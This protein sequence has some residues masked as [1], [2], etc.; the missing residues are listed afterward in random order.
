VPF[1]ALVAYLFG[2]TASLSPAIATAGISSLALAVIFAGMP[3]PP[4][5]ALVNSGW[6][7]LGAVIQ[8]VIWLIV[9]RRERRIFV[10]RAVSA[11]IAAIRALVA[12]SA[13]QSRSVIRAL[14]SLESARETLDC[15]G[16]PADEERALRQSLSAAVRATRA[17]CCWLLLKVPGEEDRL[18][19]ALTLSDAA[20]QLDDRPWPSG[21]PS[22]HVPISAHGGAERGLVDAL[23]ELQQS[24]NA[25][26]TYQAPAEVDL[27]PVT[28][29]RAPQ[30]R[31]TLS[32]VVAALTPGSEAARRGLRMAVG[33]G[34]AELVTVLFP[35]VHSFW[36]PLTVVFT[37]R[38]DWAFTLV[39]GVNRTLGNLGAVIVLPALM[40]AFGG[41]P[42][43]LALV[44]T[45]LAAVTFRWFFGNYALASF[46]LAGTVL[47]LDYALYPN[48]DLFLGRIIAAVL[49]ALLSLLVAYLMPVWRSQDAP[50]QVA[51]F[52]ASLDALTNE[53]KR[54]LGAQ[55][56][57][58]D[59]DS[60]QAIADA[61]HALTALE[62]TASA[63]LL[64]PR[65]VGDVVA[66][67]LVAATG[68]R[69]L[70]D[71]LGLSFYSTCE[72]DNDD[73]N[74]VQLVTSRLD[75]TRA[76]L[77]RVTKKFQASLPA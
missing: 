19:V 12:H 65:P 2:G 10:R 43:G 6:V 49:G 66:L 37:L 16:L 71:R 50:A 24:V 5:Q 38:S 61:R 20:R 75:R 74:E 77:E 29:P 48:D 56:P 60:E 1:I 69:L 64:E 40:L 3:V 4:E 26:V 58:A 76:D 72:R 52:T 33:V 28:H 36:L 30:T 23:T 27:L 46:G 55:V 51:A 7:A 70:S 42:W 13:V 39:R 45:V 63:A 11:K 14:D 73:S 41:S 35:E 54:E 18:R 47:V 22:A 15:S 21:T 57:A 8:S 32:D 34:V 62:P 17:T 44:L 25:V 53:V 31:T 9:W 59:I 68:T 67:T